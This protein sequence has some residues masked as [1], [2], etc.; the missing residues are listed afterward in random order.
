MAQ[1]LIDEVF[2][3]LDEQTMVVPGTGTLDIVDPSL[4]RSPGAVHG[5]HRSLEAQ[6]KTLLEEHPLSQVLIPM[7]GI[8]V[9][10]A[11]TLLATVSDGTRFPT[12]A[13]LASYAGLA[14]A[15]KSSGTSIHGEHAPRGGPPAQESHVPVRVRRPARPHLPHLLRQVPGPRK[16]PH[17]STPPPRTAPHQRAVRQAP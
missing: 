11:A 5:Q 15:T 7:P 2:H 17:T 16:D 10:T 6:I 1:R 13:H 3:A 8:A 4:A 14:P 12:A 9:S